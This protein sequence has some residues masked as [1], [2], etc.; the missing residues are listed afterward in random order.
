MPHTISPRF[1]QDRTVLLDGVPHDLAH[2]EPFKISF[3][4]TSL[5]VTTPWITVATGTG[6]YLS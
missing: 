3:A 6:R 5:Q 2:D 4:L 1:N